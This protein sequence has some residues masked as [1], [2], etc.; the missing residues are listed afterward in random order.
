MGEPVHRDYLGINRKILPSDLGSFEGQGFTVEEKFDG[1]WCR[2]EVTST[3]GT[4]D[5]HTRHNNRITSKLETFQSTFDVGTVLIGEW[6]PETDELWVHDIISDGLRSLR[7]MKHSER[8]FLLE[9]RFEREEMPR[10]HL[11]PSYENGFA[12]VYESV[13]LGNGEGVVLKHSDATY[14]S[15]LKSKKTGMWIKVKP[16]YEKKK[17]RKSGSELPGRWINEG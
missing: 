12:A 17:E 6:M 7:N 2:F 5:L 1:W 11:I 15:R 13:M 3:M 4:N 16:G 9:M 14:S 8:R 10:I